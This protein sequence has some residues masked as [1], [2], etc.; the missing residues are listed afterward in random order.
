MYPIFCIM[1]NFSLNDDLRDLL[2]ATAYLMLKSRT[3]KRKVRSNLCECEGIVT[4]EFKSVSL[5]GTAGIQ[6]SA[7]LETPRGKLKVSYMVR[8]QHLEEMEETEYSAWVG[9]DELDDV[10]TERVRPNPIHRLSKAHQKN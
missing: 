5:Y 1:F 4:T 10:P 9:Y 7:E 2:F 3:S 6:F 8:H